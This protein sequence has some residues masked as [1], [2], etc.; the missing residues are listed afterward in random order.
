MQDESD[1]LLF[2]PAGSL[3]A[4]AEYRAMTPEKPAGDAIDEIATMTPLLAAWA[5]NAF[6]DEAGVGE[7]V[8]FPGHGGITFSFGVTRGGRLLDRL[9]IKVPPVGVAQKDNADVLRQ[10]PIL[11]L[12]AARGVRV[13]KVRAWGRTE[14][15]PFPVPF[16]IVDH[17]RG[18]TLGDIF[19]G[20]MTVSGDEARRLHDQGIAEL[21]AIHATPWDVPELEGWSSI[22]PLEQEVEHWVPILRK[23]RDPEWIDHG[24]RVRERLLATVPAERQTGI[25]HGDFY[26]NNW[27]FH[28]GELSAVLD[29]ENAIV[30]PQLVDIGW[31]CMMWD[32]KSWG[33]KRRPWIDPALDPEWILARY[34]HHAGR[35]VPQAGWY[36]ALAGYRLAC[37]T[38][39]YLRLHRI[40]RRVDPVW[41]VFGD[42][43][44][45]M[46]DQAQALLDAGD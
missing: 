45:H 22:R 6:G 42:G 28:E 26:P 41:E 7:V 4:A 37:L 38:S 24:L 19:D 46:L 8:R 2:L 33:P 18:G 29:W 34:E 20:Q 16:I 12:M 25:V 31:L 27:L 9:V 40:G 10:V 23:G 35:Q 39:Y 1:S 43:F 21:A 15:G 13:P 36:R 11:Q 5:R 32:P 30:G 17:V 14:D 44:H 3:A